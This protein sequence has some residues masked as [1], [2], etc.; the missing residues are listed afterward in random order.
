MKLLEPITVRGMALRNRTIMAPMQTNAGYRS[1][2]GIAY[3]TERA[4]G[5]IGA[6]TCAA[7]PVDILVSDEAWGRQG[8]SAE[9][10]TGMRRLIDEVHA[11]GAKIG[12]QLMHTNYFPAGTG[13]DD[14]RGKPI[15]PSA[16]IESDPPRHP[17]ITPGQKLHMPTI[18][19]VQAII[20]KFA[21]AARS[22]K[23][24][25][26]DFVMFHGA[27]GYLP[28]QFFSPIDNHRADRYGGDLKRR[29]RFGVEAIQAMRAAVGDYPIFYRLGAEEAVP[30]GIVVS[31]AA[32]FA[33]ELEKAGVDCLDVSV[34]DYLARTIPSYYQPMGTYAY[35]AE[36][37]K[38]RVSIP[39]SAVGRFNDP[40]VA[41]SVL[42]QGKAD[43]ITIG[44]QTFADPHFVRKIQEG[45][46][47]EVIPCLSCNTCEDT[48]H[49]RT[50]SQCSVN[51]EAGR[52]LEFQL[53]PAKKV[54]KI[55]VIGG[56]PAG[57][58]TAFYAARR[59]HKVTL[60]EKATKLGGQLNEAAVPPHKE[61]VAAFCKSLAG[62]L[63]RNG[64]EVKLG[65]EMTA[66][67][68]VRLKPDSVVVATGATPIIPNFPGATA[69]DL[70]TAVEVL[71]GKPVGE[72]VVIV[73]GG[74]IGCETALYLAD[75]G[76]KITIVEMLEDFG[77]DIGNATKPVLRSRLD[78]AGVRIEVQAKV[79]EVTPRGVRAQRDGKSET[80][81]GDTVVIAVGM[82][83]QSQL[84]KELA[85]K[86]PELYSVGDC[87]QPKKIAGATAD[88]ARIGRDI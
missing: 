69:A 76:K 84:A 88:G 56:G 75:K 2:R 34:G 46:I 41:E 36:A 42:K 48:G 53:T 16:V 17:W 6:I 87:V 1:R 65:Q 18:A 43:L 9:F 58:E 26:Y 82:K 70:A 45:K 40:Q 21:R 22:V 61:A 59:G 52:E 27:H 44:R 25:G 71:N 31:E 10:V 14:T 12:L 35:L 85:G 63:Q 30:G 39:V 50:G 80:F 47:N 67:A 57:M 66:D 86:V 11:A 3:Y 4:K 54:K 8:A 72:N 7:V 5:G 23:E 33:V 78:R 32:E 51:P 55:F 15:A 81:A 68:I 37:V 29:M 13:L 64:V 77:A 83:P 49:Y 73:G 28:C 19:E 62:H 79:E 20:E 24:A 38:K 74:M 60:F